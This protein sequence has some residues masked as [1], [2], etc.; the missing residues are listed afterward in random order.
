MVHRHLRHFKFDAW[1][2][3]CFIQWAQLGLKH[4]C[5]MLYP[6]PSHDT[7]M[8]SIR[9]GVLHRSTV[10]TEREVRGEGGRDRKG[11][12]A[13]RLGDLCHGCEGLEVL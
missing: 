7:T 2:W 5:R 4:G 3:A 1:I 11:E 13:S 6:L 12:I 10:I 8:I 9:P